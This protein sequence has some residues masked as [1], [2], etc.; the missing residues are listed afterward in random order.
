[1]VCARRSI[2]L[3]GGG[4][5]ADGDGEHDEGEHDEG[6][7]DEGAGQSPEGLYLSKNNKSGYEGVFKQTLSAYFYIK[8]Q[9]KKLLSGGQKRNVYGFETAIEGARM[10]RRLV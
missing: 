10:Y 1:M 6:E 5:D 4:D 7:H 3:K 2:R 9:K 8:L